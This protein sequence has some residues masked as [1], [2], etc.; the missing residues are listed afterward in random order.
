MRDFRHHSSV[1]VRRV[2]NDSC[3]YLWETSQ[4]LYKHP[5]GGDLVVVSHPHL[6]TPSDVVLSLVNIC[7]YITLLQPPDLQLVTF[8]LPRALE[9]LAENKCVCVTRSATIIVLRVS[10]LTV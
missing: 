3:R 6:I 9:T 10:G 2:T 4:Q 5:C 8:N 1:I 7:T